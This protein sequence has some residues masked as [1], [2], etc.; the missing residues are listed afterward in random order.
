MCAAVSGR[1][2][3]ALGL[4]RVPATVLETNIRSERVARNCGFAYAGLLRASRRVR[5]VPGN[6]KA[7][8]RLAG[9]P[10]DPRKRAP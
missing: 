2:Y 7:Y 5:G 6:F 9:D 3:G 1:S 10:G 8:A 4:Q